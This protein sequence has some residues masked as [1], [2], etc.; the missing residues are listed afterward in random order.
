MPDIDSLSLTVNTHSGPIGSQPLA[1]LYQAYLN[2]Q[3]A[4]GT[5]TPPRVSSRCSPCCISTPRTKCWWTYTRG[6][7]AEVPQL[8][9]YLQNTLGMQ[10]ILTT[11]AKNMVSG[12]LPMGDLMALGNVPAATGSP[13]CPGAPDR[14]RRYPGR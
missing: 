12:F 10:S 2:W 1:E 9:T 11:P 4:G 3:A 13:Q 6:R 7:R 8:Q 5:G 14:Q